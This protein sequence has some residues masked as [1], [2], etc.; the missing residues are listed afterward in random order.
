M[1]VLATL[2]AASGAAA[3]QGPPGRGGPPEAPRP[4]RD[5]A[6]VDFT[7]YWV[8]V[9]SEDWRWRMV[10]PIRGDVAS[11]PVTPEART[12]AAAWDPAKD[13]AAGLACKAYGAAAIMRRPGRVHITWQDERTL[14][15][16]L[17][18]G[19]QTRIFHFGNAPAAAGAKPSW[20]GVSVANW[21]RPPQG[22]E[23]PD[24]AGIFST[25]TGTGGR[26]LEVR[27]TGLREGYL[28]K[29]GVPYSAA[30]TVDEFFDYR[31]HPDGS[32]WFTVTTVARSEERR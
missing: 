20:Q 14:K 4:P 2:L 10:T 3:A 29:N 15:L 25:R 32:E 27:T 17:D 11:I 18:E 23:P 19:T 1:L 28:R 12:I 5:A 31:R 30:T 7:G 8:A 26:A 13:E 21:E 16:E 22:I 9:V 6:P 24:L